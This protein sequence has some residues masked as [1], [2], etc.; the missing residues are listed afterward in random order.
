MAQGSGERDDLRAA[1]RQVP[2][3]D[4]GDESG[5]IARWRARAEHASDTYQKRAQI[6]PLLG[7]P[8]A[9][10]ARYTARQG[11]LLASATAFRLFLWLLPLA[12]T[13]AGILAAVTHDD[14]ASVASAAKKAG[15]TGA[16]S[17]QVV[18]ALRD[19]DRSWVLAVITGTVLFLWAT[20]TLMRNLTVVNAHVW[21][22]PL[23]RRRQKDVLLTSL[24][25]AGAW[26]LMFGFTAA[27]NRLSRDIFGG[28]LLVFVVQ[29]TAVGALWVLICSQLPDR[30]ESWR[31]LL[32]GAAVMGYGLS[33]MNTVGRIYLPAR[34]AHSSAIY[35]SLGIA[36]VMLL[37]LLLVGQLIVSSA[38]INTV[39]FDFRAGRRQAYDEALVR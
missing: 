19:G 20:R 36:S 18:V 30:R 32:P 1:L 4:G 17:Q 38:V 14:S 10:L 12:L 33:L 26:I 5:R 8:L 22:A 31:D 23:P 28:A 25:F 7:L 29:G 16:A 3:P 35:G 37:W 6:Q 2:L 34:F 24:I 27:L 21:G 11:V 13:A 39:W 9:F 15:L